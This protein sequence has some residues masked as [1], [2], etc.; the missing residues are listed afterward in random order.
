M[1]IF[2]QLHGLHHAHVQKPRS[3]RSHILDV[4]DV[5][6]STTPTC[7]EQLVTIQHPSTLKEMQLLLEQIAI[8]TPK[9]D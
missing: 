7:A 9:V 8:S 6:T 4:E 2:Y 1:L 3:L 5:A